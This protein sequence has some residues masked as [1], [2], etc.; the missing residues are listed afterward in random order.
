LGEG[1]VIKGWDLG[2]ATMKKGEKSV[3]TC[4]APYAYGE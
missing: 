4:T 3:L 1:S 2:V